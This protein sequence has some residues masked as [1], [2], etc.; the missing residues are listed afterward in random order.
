MSRTKVM[1]LVWMAG[2]AAVFAAPTSARDLGIDQRVAAQAA[3]EGVYWRHRIWPDGN[4]GPKPALG[5]VV[6]EAA[7]RA[8]VENALLESKALERIWGRDRK[9][10]V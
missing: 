9:S 2:S 7:L 3:I 1:L 5:E 4:D 6:P 10:V 8:T